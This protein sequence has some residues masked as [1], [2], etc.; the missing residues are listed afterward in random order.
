M[1]VYEEVLYSTV[2]LRLSSHYQYSYCHVVALRR[3][4]CQDFDNIPPAK[5]GCVCVCV[6]VC[7]CG[8]SQK[9]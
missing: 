9:K 7:V 5:V 4:F 2:A 8:T 3:L 1:P 6:C